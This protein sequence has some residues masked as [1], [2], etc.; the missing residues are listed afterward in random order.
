MVTI[1]NMKTHRIGGNQ[2]KTT[3]LQNNDFHRA[4][5]PD[6][7]STMGIHGGIS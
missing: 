6:S 1:D 7:I 3:G 2:A 4:R 5:T